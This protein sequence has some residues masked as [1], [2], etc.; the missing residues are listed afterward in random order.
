M[1]SAPRI[2]IVVDAFKSFLTQS[3]LFEE[4]IGDA[5]GR[6]RNEGV[7]LSGHVP[8]CIIGSDCGL[9]FFDFVVLVFFR[10]NCIGALELLVRHLDTEV[11]LGRRWG[12]VLLLVLIY[13]LV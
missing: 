10:P 13:W 1:F 6:V 3:A 12:D 11:L 5:G 9:H 7:V 4:L 2:G 8:N